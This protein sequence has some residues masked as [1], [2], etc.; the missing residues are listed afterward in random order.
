MVIRCER[1]STLYDLDESLLSPSGSQVQ[2]TRCQHLFTAYPPSSP[3]RTLAGVP[4]QPAPPEGPAAAPT[5]PSAPA[6]PRA[7][8]V[9]ASARPAPAAAGPTKP[10]PKPVRTVPAPVYRPAAPAAGAA[11]PPGVARAPMLRRDTVGTFEARLRRSARMRWLVPSAAAAALAAIV[12]G[13]FLLSRRSDVAGASAHVEAMALAARDDAAS[14]D[15][16]IAR[17]EELERRSPPLRSVTADRALVQVLRAGSLADEGDAL[18]SRLTSRLAD[19]ER[20]RREQPPGWED[21][22][23]AA[24]AEVQALEPEVRGR[25][26]RSRALAAT[27]LESLRRVEVEAGDTPEVARALAAYHALGGAR[28]RAQ[29]AA[30]APRGAAQDPWLALAAASL[31]ARDPDRAA[32]ERALAAL[33]ALAGSHP[34]ILRGRLLLARTQAAL[35]RGTEAIATLDALLEE[36]GKHEA[37]RRLRE[38]LSAPPAAPVTAPPAPAIAE[39]SATQPR[40]RVSQPSQPPVATPPEAVDS[41]APLA[42][43]APAPAAAAAPPAEPATAPAVAPRGAAQS[44]A[45]AGGPG[46]EAGQPP[47]RPAPRPAPS[48]DPDPEPLRPVDGG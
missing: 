17:L 45:G 24:A 8:G 38:E 19:R 1:C 40:R 27:A 7:R 23:R 14:L 47:P 42:V 6:L 41:A 16:A 22:E 2:C 12:A 25:H 4:A 20:L 46:G 34:E 39:K 32:R 29:A 28:E 13:W 11:P 31:E 9:P 44:E 26:D 33:R 10:G 37:A 21:G 36:N 30:R 18:A 35:G 48:P 3:G 43:P 15:Q 5:A